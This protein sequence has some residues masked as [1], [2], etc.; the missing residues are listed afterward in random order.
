MPSFYTE[1][2]KFNQWWLWIF[3][4]AFPVFAIYPFDLNSI[5]Y[6]YLIIGIAIPLF[7]YFLELRISVNNDGLYYQ[8]FP[9]HFKK[10]VIKF[11]EIKKV[12]ALTYRP[13][14]D[15]GGWGIKYGFHGK[16][17]NVSGNL[18]VKIHLS[19]GKNIL[20]GSRKHKEFEK[21]IKQAMKL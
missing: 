9:I 1:I 16:A 17:Y 13:I 2:Q 7:F 3:L 5:N 12:E 6:T 15:Y 19:N 14:V 10:H 18:G 20:F 4:L 21:A 11:S 8:F